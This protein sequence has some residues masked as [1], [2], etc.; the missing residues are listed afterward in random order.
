MI[1]LSLKEGRGRSGRIF[2]PNERFPIEDGEAS[3]RRILTLFDLNS[4][5]F[6]ELVVRRLRRR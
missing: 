3:E 2:V 1:L 4:I 6:L 5:L